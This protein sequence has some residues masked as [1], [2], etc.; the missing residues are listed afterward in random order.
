METVLVIALQVALIAVLLVG[1]RRMPA[2]AWNEGFLS[3]SET[4]ALQGLFAMFIVF[5]HCGQRVLY[6]YLW[7]G[8]GFSSGLTIVSLIG[9]V[10]VGYFLFCS[11][12]GLCRS[13]HNK[14]AYL[15][16][17]L[18]RRPLSLLAI[19]Y[20]CNTLYLLGRVCFGE[21]FDA[22]RLVR[23]ALGIELANPNSWYVIALPVLYTLFYFS[24]RNATDDSQI[25]RRLFGGVGIYVLVGL[26]VT[27]LFSSGGYLAF[28]GTWWYDSAMLF[29]LGYLFGYKGDAIAG[30]MRRNFGKSVALS[31]L[32]CIGAFIPSAF[33]NFY[34]LPDTASGLIH[35]LFSLLIV[36]IHNISAVGFVWAMMCLSLKRRIESRALAF[37]GS[38]TLELYLMHG[39]FVQ[40]FFAPFYDKGVGILNIEMSPAYVVAVLACGTLA[41]LMF[42]QLTRRLLARG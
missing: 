42:R 15:D 38:I 20:A 12:Y 21:T 18:R 37:Y 29:P 2:G 14:K 6:S 16:G 27:T 39:F 1:S 19:F 5:H 40:L 31:L 17:F 33:L 35:Y 30:W 36:L 10:F 8:L 32:L 34:Y 23:L 28:T 7:D 24:A 26:V 41:A 9:Y 13:F 11:G 4:K 22:L 3:L 25:A